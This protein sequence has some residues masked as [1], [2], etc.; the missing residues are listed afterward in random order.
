MLTK[1]EFK[2]NLHIE[3]VE[4]V[5]VFVLME[6][7]HFLLAGR[8]Y[9]LLAPLIDGDRTVDR[10]VDELQEKISPA[11]IYYALMTMKQDGY[12]VEASDFM[13]PQ[14]AA[15]SDLLGA[16]R[17][18]A[19]YKLK[20][21]RVGVR[22]FGAVDRE[23]LMAK[24]KSL[25]IQVEDSGDIE[26]VLTDDYLRE[27]LAAYNQ[28]AL[29]AKHPWM[30][31]KPIGTTLWI[32]PIF[33]PEKTGCWDCLA[34]RLR[35]NRP[36]ERFIQNKTGIAKVFP[37]STSILQS[38]SQ[39]AL[40][41]A[42]IELVKW[43][44]QP[45]L[46]ELEGKL[47]TLDAIALKTQNHFLV[48][49]SQCSSCSTESDRSILRQPAPIVLTSRKKT[50]TEDGGHRSFSPEETLKKYQHH[51]SH[52]IGAVKEL[53][54]FSLPSEGLMHLYYSG[55]NFSK[56][57]DDLYFLRQGGRNSSAGKGKTDLQAKA[58][59]LCEALE[60]YSGLFQGDEI[61]FKGIYKEM[62]EAAI[63]PHS[64]MNFS[65]EQYRTRLEWNERSGSSFNLTNEPFDEEAEI[66]W[67]PVWS[68]TNRA[69]K[70]LP[71]AFCYFGYPS[72]PKEVF[73]TDSNGN[74]A[75]N[76][77]EEA[78]IQGFMELV[79]RDSVALWWYNRVKRPAVDL[80][81]FNEPYC[82]GI[83]KYYQ[84]LNRE[85]WVLDLTSD[86]NIPVFVAIS[87]RVDRPA[88]DI[89]FGFGAHFD[90]KIALLRALTEM[91]QILPS[92][93][94]LGWNNTYLNWDK[95]ATYWWQNATIE[96]QPYLVPDENV[97]AKKYEDF[98]QLASDD[99]YE[100][101]MTCV[102]LTKERGMEMLVL[103]QTRPD[104]GLNVVKVIVPGMRHFWKRLAPGRLYD[105]PV[106]LGWLDAPLKEEELNP[107]PVFF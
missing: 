37:S 84:N 43:I 68:L 1:P 50:F 62:E 13:P 64:C 24:L 10:I 22:S 106:K 98:L 44:V 35:G 5:G 17:M 96:N 103:D 27:E 40:E 90:P 100:D 97:P 60:R 25:G 15:I 77:K 32:G 16:D 51:V 9:E 81:S 59:A 49:R 83:K 2:S 76:T 85:L 93:P 45:K 73:G 34:Q 104:I 20:T 47:V 18:E 102:E 4:S 57:G 21:T 107:I 7:E 66:E 88:E 3:V 31:V 65:K 38:P 19:L 91:N 30:L 36:V 72:Y 69:F 86:F 56:M 29:A 41:Q 105:V 53:E 101:V 48:K 89:I 6:S 55:H 61:R 71:T 92:V 11:E 95:I 26:I 12:I 46:S 39:G 58:S 54:K 75:G 52:L 8:A 70:Y 82:Q 28:Q 99:L 94:T 78:I 79:E 14:V 63:H 33:V 87:R 67:T 23:P 42:A 74:A 80:E